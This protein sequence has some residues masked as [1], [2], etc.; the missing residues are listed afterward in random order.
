MLILILCHYSKLYIN[1]ELYNSAWS[2]QNLISADSASL[3]DDNGTMIGV[4]A[5]PSNI[6]WGADEY[7]YTFSYHNGLVYIVFTY[8]FDVSY[9]LLGTQ[10]GIKAF[11]G[12]NGLPLNDPQNG[13]FVNLI[14]SPQRYIALPSYT[15]SSTV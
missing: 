13:N 15:Y 10:N 1:N 4:S 12:L 5:P 14:T 8:W 9:W 11:A 3:S 6:A 7:I 2:G